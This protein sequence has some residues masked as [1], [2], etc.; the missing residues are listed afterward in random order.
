[1]VIFD[2][3]TAKVHQLDPVGTI[4]WQLL[5]GEV[6]LGELVVDLAEV[7]KTPEAQVRADLAKLFED[8][9]EHS[10][11]DSQSES[12]ASPS[13]TLGEQPAYLQDPPAP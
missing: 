13:K 9:N 10:L 3:R 6:T 8:L 12:T 4:V 2:P 7:F 11:I 5:D 1:M